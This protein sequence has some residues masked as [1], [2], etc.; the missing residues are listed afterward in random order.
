MKRALFQPPRE[1]TFGTIASV[2]M[3]IYH[4]LLWIN[5][6]TLRLLQERCILLKNPGIAVG[7]GR[8]YRLA[9]RTAAG[10]VWGVGACVDCCTGAEGAA[11]RVPDVWPGRWHHGG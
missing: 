6:Q 1:C 8:V 10:L 2:M 3:P 11:L 4:G 7:E 5:E 9:A